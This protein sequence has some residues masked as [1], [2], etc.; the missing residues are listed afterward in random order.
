[1]CA[2]VVEILLLV[3][4]WYNLDYWL[5]ETFIFKNFQAIHILIV[6]FCVFMLLCH[7]VLCFYAIIVFLCFYAI[8]LQHTV[9]F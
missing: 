8:I 9:L 7:C 1:M 5:C 6:I 3:F 4:F 2:V